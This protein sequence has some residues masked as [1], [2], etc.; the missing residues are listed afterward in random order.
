[1]LRWSSESDENLSRYDFSGIFYVSP[2]SSQNML[3]SIFLLDP[4]RDFAR[5]KYGFS[6]SALETISGYYGHESEAVLPSQL[7]RSTAKNDE[8][9]TYGYTLHTKGIFKYLYNEVSNKWPGFL[10]SHLD[11]TLSHSKIEIK[12]YDSQ[13]TRLPQSSGLWANY[14][15][16]GLTVHGL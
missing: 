3:N 14:W 4:A 1:M 8:F 10:F 5:N 12:R 16:M 9:T 2:F 15:E 13:G 7:V 11:L 6:V